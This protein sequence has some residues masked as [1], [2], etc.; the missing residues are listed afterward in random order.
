M[1]R[2]IWRRMALPR[3]LI[4][5]HRA[6]I[7]AALLLASSVGAATITP[8]IGGGIGQ[9]DGGISSG[10][11]LAAPPS[12]FAYKV[13]PSGNFYIDPMGNFILVQVS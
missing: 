5:A 9:F 3:P 11:G 4:T 13:D 2:P 12:G 8:Q 7:L 1:N 10:G 6:L